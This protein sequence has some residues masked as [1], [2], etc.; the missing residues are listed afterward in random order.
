L[1]EGYEAGVAYR[2]EP[3]ADAIKEG[4]LH[5]FGLSEE[6]LKDLGVQAHR[7]AGQHYSWQKMAQDIASVYKWVNG[8]EAQPDCVQLS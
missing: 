3:N 1:S 6:Q 2:I 5:L 4:L 7:F 8:Q